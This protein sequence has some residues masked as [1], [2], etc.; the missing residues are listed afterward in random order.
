[1]RVKVLRVLWVWGGSLGL[2][3]GWGSSAWADAEELNDAQWGLV[4]RARA[5]LDAGQPQEA[6]RLL[7]EARATGDHPR[8]KLLMG[9]ASLGQG[10]CADAKRFAVDA[11]DPL[12][13][14]KPGTDWHEEQRE[15]L[16]ARIARECP[17]RLKLDCGPTSRAFVDGAATACGAEVVIEPGIHILTATDERGQEARPRRIQADGEALTEL[18]L[19]PAGGEHG[20]ARWEPTSPQPIPE[21]DPKGE[22]YS[23][24]LFMPIFMLTA[25]TI[26]TTLGGLLVWEAATTD[27]AG[28]RGEELEASELRE[29]QAWSYG[30]MGVVVGLVEIGCGVLLWPEAPPPSE[31]PEFSV[32]PLREGWSVGLGWEF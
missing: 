18:K 7:A 32:A 25:G 1:M 20:F 31:W 23:G 6:E 16:M 21:Q 17:A 13:L 19:Y 27:H 26:T 2:C 10:R 8:L 24:G 29:I 5:A 3:L 12:F 15:A 9:E 28:L 30:V 4:T 22:A 11:A 14:A